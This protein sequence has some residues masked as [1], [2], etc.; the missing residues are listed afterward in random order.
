MTKQALKK[1]GMIETA[2]LR[3][4]G[5]ELRCGPIDLF[6]QVLFLMKKVGERID[7]ARRPAENLG[8]TELMQSSYPRF[9]RL[10]RFYQ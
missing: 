3:L 7:D 10:I 1:K 8:Q 5:L 2:A 4:Q 6:S 9:F